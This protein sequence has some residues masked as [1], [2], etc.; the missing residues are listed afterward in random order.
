MSSE[1]RSPEYTDIAADGLVEV[2]NFTFATAS[3]TIRGGVGYAVVDMN[4]PGGTAG[5][6]GVV[7]VTVGDLNS[8]VSGKGGSNITLVDPPGQSHS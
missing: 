2:H 6:K 1:H 5:T 3:V 7:T 8:G 4:T